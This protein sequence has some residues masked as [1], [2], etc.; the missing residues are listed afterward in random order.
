[1]HCFAEMKIMTN[2]NELIRTDEDE[3]DDEEEEDNSGKCNRYWS[4]TQMRI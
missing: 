3:D 4:N 1:M 2:K